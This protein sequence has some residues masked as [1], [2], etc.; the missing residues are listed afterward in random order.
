MVKKI[1][2]LLG[3]LWC[4]L[5]FC[6]YQ[7]LTL[8][9]AREFLQQ[10]PDTLSDV[11]TIP[12]EDLFKPD[13]ESEF[14]R[15][16]PIGVSRFLAKMGISFESASEKK[17]GP[18]PGCAFIKEFIS[19]REL[20]GYVHDHVV[21]IAT[22]PGDKLIAFGDLQGAFGSLVRSLDELE[23]QGIIDDNLFIKKSGYFIIFN[24]NVIG[25][26]PRSFQTLLLVATL[27]HNNPERVFWIRGKYEEDDVLRKYGVGQY[28]TELATLCDDPQACLSHLLRLIHTLPL[29]VYVNYD[30]GKQL[31]RFSG[32]GRAF[33]PINERYM[34]DFFQHGS[35]EPVSIYNIKHKIPSIDQVHVRALFQSLDGIDAF[36]QD[37]E[38]LALVDYSGGAI[39]WTLFTA[40]SP[41]QRKIN[42]FFNDSFT[43]IDLGNSAQTTSA[44]LYAR[45]ARLGE[46]FKM[47]KRYLVLTGIELAPPGIS[48]NDATATVFL[49]NY[50]R[51]NSRSRFFG[52]AAQSWYN[53]RP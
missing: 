14:R 20:A 53:A 51:F 35:I 48:R 10:N 15:S 12:T 17:F 23:R 38:G 25:R 8:S 2:I 47:R 31:I 18:C 43:L 26:D 44:V 30:Q 36:K 37:N 29:A 3:V 21:Q 34:G 1:G 49:R 11:A 6:A 16:V 40:P 46:P 7:G 41:L 5:S 39:V 4:T 13:Y 9:C 22:K 32:Y 50:R 28:I 45:D 42:K 19:Q 27:L 33:E 52:S 24:S